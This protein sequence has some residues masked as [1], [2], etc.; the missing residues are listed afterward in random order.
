MLLYLSEQVNTTQ[1]GGKSVMSILFGTFQCGANKQRVSL[2]GVI[3]SE[4]TA[5]G[6]DCT[7]LYYIKKKI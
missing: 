1:R 4:I 3:L 2:T 5:S 6:F 7:G